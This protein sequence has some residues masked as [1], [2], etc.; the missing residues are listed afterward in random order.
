MIDKY[1]SR[2]SHIVFLFSHCKGY[3]YGIHTITLQRQSYGFEI[4]FYY[5]YN[6]SNQRIDFSID[7]KLKDFNI[8]IELLYNEEP[9]RTSLI[10]YTACPFLI[11]SK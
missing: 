7:E 10:P 6:T 11:E 2:I 1:L 3:P 9:L 4:Q 8:L 5:Y